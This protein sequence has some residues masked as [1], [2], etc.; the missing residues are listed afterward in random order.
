MTPDPA[1]RRS[2]LPPPL[3]VLLGF[4]L[5]ALLGLI[6]LDVLE[7]TYSRLGI[8]HRQFA[9]LLFAS[10]LGRGVN[11]RLGSLPARDDSGTPG[12]PILLAVN[13][14]GAVIPA[15]LSVYLLFLHRLFGVGAIATLVVAGVSH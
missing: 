15:L 7:Y 2:S 12:T 1:V 14:G 8:G 5:L 11:V 6:E 9:G 10:L 13:L 4:V 3:T